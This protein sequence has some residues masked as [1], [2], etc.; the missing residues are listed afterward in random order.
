MNCKPGDLAVIVRSLVESN[1][2][3]MVRII[4]IDETC[5][6]GE[7]RVEALSRLWDQHGKFCLP[8]HIGYADDH[9]L[10]PL[11]DPGDDA[12]DE[13]LLWKPTLREILRLP[14]REMTGTGKES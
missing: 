2:G 1:V 12:V 7:W 9:R 4:G 8:G 6:P 13:T 11:N 5:E 3:G 10:R 14:V